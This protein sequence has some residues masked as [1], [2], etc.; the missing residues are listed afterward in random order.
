MIS[1]R[2]KD[3]NSTKNFFTNFHCH[4]FSD[5]ALAWQ[6][7]AQKCLKNDEVANELKKLSNEVIK[8]SKP[9]DLDESYED[10][11]DT[12]TDTEGSATKLSVG[13]KL[14]DVKLSNK[15]QG[16]LQDLLLEGDLLETSM[17][18]SHQIWKLLQ[19]SCFR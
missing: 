5:R 4:F 7:K 8:E 10:T 12:D 6:Q 16:L 18:E 14:P 1:I 11:E 9:K 2:P 3:L 17:D 19:V 13:K 15:M